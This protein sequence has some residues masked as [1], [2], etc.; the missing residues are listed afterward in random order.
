MS[1]SGRKGAL[2]ENHGPWILA[3]ILTEVTWQVFESQIPD[4]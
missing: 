2:G 4:F 1:S 3:Q